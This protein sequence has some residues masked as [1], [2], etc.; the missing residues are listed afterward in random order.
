MKDKSPSRQ[1]TEVLHLA[2]VFME[3]EHFHEGSEKKNLH[4]SLEK[5]SALNEVVL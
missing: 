2:S 5:R 4:E 1:K 3:L